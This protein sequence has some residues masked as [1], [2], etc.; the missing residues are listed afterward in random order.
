MR[1]L[2]ATAKMAL[3]FFTLVQ[4]RSKS[5]C[6]SRMIGSCHPGGPDLS[7]PLPGYSASMLLLARGRNADAASAVA[8]QLLDRR[9]A[10]C[11]VV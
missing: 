11:R 9:K 7:P 6:K 4:S 10:F 8:H 5:A 1:S 3:R 2:R